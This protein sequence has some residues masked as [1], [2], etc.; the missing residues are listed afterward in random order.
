ATQ[1]LA[2][3]VGG[4]DE[5]VEVETCLDAQPRAHIDEVF[6]R[7]ISAGHLREG[8]AANTTDAGIED[9]DAS[10]HRGHNVR[11]GLAVGVVEMKRDLLGWNA[12][13]AQRL[14][15]SPDVAG[16]PD[17]DRVAQRELVATEVEKPPARLDHRRSGRRPIPWIREDHREIAA[18]S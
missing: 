10:V 4:R 12:R 7:K 14:D 16:R 1:L 15:K 17:S 2:E 3:P 18:D 8:R 6:S 13:A 11:E 5:L 9:R